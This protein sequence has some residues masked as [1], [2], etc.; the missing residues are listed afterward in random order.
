MALDRSCWLFA[1]VV[2][3]FGA[4]MDSCFCACSTVSCIDAGSLALVSDMLVTGFGGFGLFV[5][6]VFSLKRGTVE[7]YVAR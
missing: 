5:G 4:C 6:I 7:V 3:R 2:A 1:Q